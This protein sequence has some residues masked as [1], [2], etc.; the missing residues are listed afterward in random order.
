MASIGEGPT[1]SSMGRL[2]WRA[3]RVRGALATV[4]SVGL[5]VASTPVG[6]EPGFGT[7]KY[8][9]ALPGAGL[10]NKPPY[11]TISCP[12]TS[13][14]VAA[15]DNF[16]AESYGGGRAAI[17]TFTNGAWGAPLAL[18]LPANLAVTSGFSPGI[19][20]VSCWSVGNCAAVGE[21]PTYVLL[22][23]TAAVFEM[24]FV[25]MEASGTWGVAQELALPT[26]TNAIGFSTGVSCDPAGDCTLVGEYLVSTINPPTFHIQFATFY[27]RELAG[28]GVWSPTSIG[29]S[30]GEGS[31]SVIPT[32]ISC[33]DAIDC[34][35]VLITPLNDS[36]AVTET[37]GSW[38]A[39]V[40]LLA[41]P[42]KLWDALA[43][44]CP[45]LGGCVAVGV[46]SDTLAHLDNNVNLVP[47][48]ALERAG[49]WLQ[50]G[51]LPQ[52][53]LTPAASGGA[54]YGLS[55][56]SSALCEAVGAATLAPDGLHS[57]P[58]AY[59]FAGGKWSSAGL[60]GGP[61]LAGAARGTASAFLDVSCASLTL[62]RTVGSTSLG[63]VNS[64]IYPQYAFSSA[65]NPT[66]PL[67]APS[68]PLGLRVTAAA[69]A[70]LASWRAPGADGGSG[71]LSFTLSVSAPRLATRQ[72]VVSAL[73][74]RVGGLVKGRAYRASVTARNA[75]GTSAPSAAVVFSAR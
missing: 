46:D 21:Y 55:C 52:P 34:T 19:F 5:L 48:F 59:S 32:S 10:I 20:S 65:L 74:C 23:T 42:H 1:T 67:V 75:Q 53:L 2:A 22:G 51:Q 50:A 66:L 30:I 56:A 54:L 3:A 28:T 26:T 12:T 24:P 15:G 6:A 63:T 14:C 17:I 38:G 41:P 62:C 40:R 18:G 45:S 70:V 47:A 73:S 13:W 69:G 27:A 35:Y 33:L 11:G 29:A 49:S 60:Y 64:T 72:C 43:I 25:A 71:I 7:A 8:L 68:P 44:R 31:D 37:T 16:N 39:P 9:P 57:V 61:L 58:E 4:L 36:Y